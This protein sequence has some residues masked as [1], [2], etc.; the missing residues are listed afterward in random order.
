MV[1][2]F[3]NELLTKISRVV[4]TQNYTT[5][6]QIAEATRGMKYEDERHPTMPKKAKAESSSRGQQ[7]RGQSS[8]PKSRCRHSSGGQRQ[9]SQAVSMAPSSG[10]VGGHGTGSSLL[11]I[12]TCRKRQLRVCGKAANLCFHCRQPRHTVAEC[13]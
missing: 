9:S 4:T 6:F 7:G 1:S 12:E 13:L 2:K 10:R 3:L 8:Q 5:V 11:F